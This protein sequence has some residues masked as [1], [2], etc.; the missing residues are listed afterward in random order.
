[1]A[2]S[3]RFAPPL[4]G[5]ERL[6]KRVP[7]FTGYL[8][9]C[10]V[11][12]A[13]KPGP[14]VILSLVD[15]LPDLESPRRGAALAR[16]A[17]RFPLPPGCDGE[18]GG[19]E[20]PRH[21]SVVRD[22][23]AAVDDDGPLPGAAEAA[24]SDG[25]G[26][27]AGRKRKDRGKQGAGRGAGNTL[28][29]SCNGGSWFS[30]KS[31]I[32]GLP[33][34][35]FCCQENKL[36]QRDA[37]EASWL[38]ARDGWASGF[39]AAGRSKEGLASAGVSITRQAREGLGY[40]PG[41]ETW[42]RSP[43][44]SPG[45]LVV[46][47][48]E[49]RGVGTILILCAYFWVTE[50]W[51]ERNRALLAALLEEAR[52][53]GGMWI[54][55]AD[56]NLDPDELRRS[57][58][59]EGVA[60]TVV[61]P[62]TMTCKAGRSEGSCRD[63]FL[64]DRRLSPS[65]DRV[66][67]LDN[68][69]YPHWL[70][71]V[72]IR[73]DAPSRLERVLKRPAAFPTEWPKDRPPVAGVAWPS[74][75]S[76]ELVARGADSLT[77]AWRGI[78]DSAEQ[79]WCSFFQ[80]PEGN[81]QRHCGRG[82]GPVF[83]LRPAMG[84][85]AGPV[86]LGTRR[87]RSF[88]WLAGKLLEVSMLTAACHRDAVAGLPCP[89]ARKMHLVRLVAILT[90]SASRAAR[91]GDS[92]AVW[93]S[94]LSCFRGWQ[95]W[96][97]GVDTSVRH[98]EAWSS[99]A[100]FG[101]A[102][103]ERSM[104]VT[105]RVGWRKWVDRHSAGSAAALHRYSQ[106]RA[107]WAP[108]AIG[109]VPCLPVGDM[110]AAVELQTRFWGQ[111]WTPEE[112][113]LAGSAPDRPWRS[114]LPPEDEPQP[115]PP[116]VAEFRAKCRGFKAATGMGVEAIHP[117][118]F[119]ALSDEGVAAIIV[120]LMA[121][122]ALGAFP[123]QVTLIFYFLIAK[124]GGGRRPIGL[125][126]TLIRVWEA[127]RKDQ[128]REWEDRAVTERYDWAVAGRSAEGGAWDLAFDAECASSQGYVTVAAFLDL[129][130]A[131]EYVRLVDLWRLGRAAGAPFY[132][133]R[134]I[135]EVFSLPR[136]FRL[137][138]ACG[139]VLVD[140][141]RSIVP[142]SAFACAALRIIMVNIIE[143]VRAVVPGIA[144]MLY[145]D[146]LA[147]TATARSA[148]VAGSRV[149]DAVDEF[150]GA[151]EDSF[152]F[153]V[154]RRLRRLGAWGKSVVVASTAAAAGMLRQRFAALGLLTV[155]LAAH[156]GVDFTGVRARRLGKVNGRWE[157][158]RKR[159]RHGLRKLR[160]AGGATAKI[161]KAGLWRS[162]IYGTR[163]L[164]MSSGRI[165]EARR[166]AAA[167]L[168]GKERGRSLA[169]LLAITRSDPAEDANSAP[170]FAWASAVFDADKPQEQLQEVWRSAVK[171]LGPEPN[172][173]RVTGP[174]EAH[175]ATLRRLRWTSPCAE[176]V[177]TDTGEML[178]L[179]E[180]S[181]LHVRQRVKEATRRRLWTSWHLSQPGQ[182]LH[183]APFIAPIHR[184][185]DRFAAAGKK[186]HLG[187]VRGM[188]TGSLRSMQRR[189]ELGLVDSDRC[190]ACGIGAGTW[191]HRLWV[192]PGQRQA[193]A[194]VG[195]RHLQNLGATAPEGSLLWGRGLMADPA[196]ALPPVRRE[197]HSEFWLRGVVPDACMYT[198]LAFTDGSGG[199]Y[200]QWPDLRRCGWAGVAVTH[201]GEL[202]FGRYGPVPAAVQ[203][204]PTAELWALYQVVRYAVPPL[205]IGIDCAMVVQGWRRGHKWC[206][207]SRR[208]HAW[209]W[210][211]I[212][213]HLSDLTLPGGGPGVVL[214]K[215]KA[216]RTLASM[217][218]ASDLEW[219]NYRANG[220]ADEGAR[221]GAEVG[222]LPPGLAMGYLRNFR[223]VEDVVTFAANLSCSSL[224]V[225]DVAK[226]PRVP[227]STVLQKAAERGAWEVAAPTPNCNWDALVVVDLHIDLL[228]AA[229]GPG[230]DLMVSGDRLLWCRRCGSYAVRGCARTMKLACRGSVDA[231][232][233][234]GWA[235]RRRIGQ[236]VKGM[237]PVTNEVVGAVRSWA[238][239][240][241]PTAQGQP[242]SADLGPGGRRVPVRRSRLPRVRAEP[243][244][245]APQE[246]PRA[247]VD[248]TG[249]T[250][251]CAWRPGR[252]WGSPVAE[253]EGRG[254]EDGGGAAA[255]C[256]SASASWP[257]AAAY[258]DAYSGSGP[259][260][261][262]SSEEDD[263][264]LVQH[265]ARV[266]GDLAE[267]AAAESRAAGP[268]LSASAS[269]D[270]PTGGGGG[271]QPRWWSRWQ[272]RR[273][274][275]ATADDEKRKA[276]T[277]WDVEQAALARVAARP[278]GWQLD[279]TEREPTPRRCD[280]GAPGAASAV[281]PPA[282][283]ALAP[284]V[285]PP[286]AEGAEPKEKAD[287]GAPQ[288]A[289]AAALD[290][291]ARRAAEA[292]AFD[293]RRAALERVAPLPAG[294]FVA[295]AGRSGTSAPPL[296]VRRPRP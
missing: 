210:K 238:P 116:T 1:L 100:Q 221:L 158:A 279:W 130:K 204:T 187:W 112:G 231:P 30:N 271:G 70:V 196:A 140:V 243:R 220:L 178:R 107:A 88:R 14:P 96:L 82:K 33:G 67:V 165:K 59:L 143:R 217:A 28:L 49:L 125:L 166:M 190:Q 39:A 251:R 197:D 86:A 237:H 52:A 162:M 4:G 95:P 201:T 191:Q 181:P 58:L 167:S 133:F 225:A 169:L 42:D 44:E 78:C 233:N 7:S 247:V 68:F 268:P 230:H 261:G 294:T 152:G 254:S 209:L 274:S 106:T 235:R 87:A 115:P 32:E 155:L 2:R 189:Y 51:S 13:R 282:R 195:M 31:E 3:P 290:A 227:R 257:E 20:M 80:I 36:P 55:A 139:R 157:K 159:A 23:A 184:V 150:I 180:E 46:A 90:A 63:Y 172:W 270:A 25:W 37:D 255:A 122:E 89:A 211:K 111:I 148:E 22:I 79:E 287:A 273:A 124:A 216:H 45:R 66:E 54:A 18:E 144:P 61:A 277:A 295:R 284:A 272:A 137:G 283:A 288:P 252:G 65:I 77:G 200:S 84:P 26:D 236:L 224:L 265:F 174:G 118:W 10:R 286:R 64:V 218:G 41:A 192:C 16:P 128:F 186:G 234:D 134:M 206:T 245:A 103:E 246:P 280:S 99:F 117:R 198:G 121:M 219:R 145:V 199:V 292:A 141:H 17:A 50:G 244:A 92:E 289:T 71:A 177:V 74:L 281:A 241:R 176:V 276:E 205:I 212:W 72:R 119:A 207:S 249:A 105:R 101:A 232:G 76:E 19:L 98:L 239:A 260:G 110:G 147:L 256:G 173:N 151:A 194:E 81:A 208:K 138:S 153:N 48:T 24:E 109:S 175:V 161:F 123:A 285:G 278:P 248:L 170:V 293:R 258:D 11:G 85:K 93:R 213:F 6:P 275:K 135:M 38:L 21:S 164:G 136:A 73:H 253:Q 142:G 156:L 126:A 168:P 291:A 56:W 104:A 35:I 29:I 102:E 179:D 34:A 214:F 229:A 193:R 154:S 183:P 228:A 43:P 250:I 259:E 263:A 91:L 9:A 215:V 203:T 182:P 240:A 75:S 267:L 163:V 188:V 83:I 69:H 57:P 226:G 40:A 242:F 27:R 262:N 223:L 47:V 132:I 62:D 202:R 114:A 131:F 266:D 53:W 149:R 113:S 185:M 127:V 8:E 171:R 296:R 12:E 5:N 146:D 264:I 94:Y 120:L 269:G 108:E 129:V 97:E 60:A 15:L 160:R 222:E